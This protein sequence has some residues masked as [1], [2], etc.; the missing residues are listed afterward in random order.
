MPVV[1][2]HG[3]QIQPGV[4]VCGVT[5]PQRAGLLPLTGGIIGLAVTRSGHNREP[6]IISCPPVVHVLIFESQ[7]VN[8]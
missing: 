8:S 7:G 6:D 4:R 2:L 3:L 1:A 5:Y